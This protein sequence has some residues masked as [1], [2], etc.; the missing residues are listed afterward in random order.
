MIITVRA[1]GWVAVLAPLAAP[2]VSPSTAVTQA[3]TAP[4]RVITGRAARVPGGAPAAARHRRARSR[5]IVRTR[6]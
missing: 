3:S 1:G 5:V 2:A 4:A 6:R